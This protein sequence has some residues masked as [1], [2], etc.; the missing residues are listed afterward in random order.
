M[1]QRLLNNLRSY[2]NSRT[3]RG[4]GFACYQFNIQKF[5]IFPRIYTYPK[6]DGRTKRCELH[7]RKWF[8]KRQRRWWWRESS[9]KR[10][11]ESRTLW[12][13]N[14]TPSWA[15]E[16]IVFFATACTLLRDAW[17]GRSSGEEKVVEGIIIICNGRVYFIIIT[18]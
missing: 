1:A 15:I 5:R 9:K 7:W 2:K 11:N 13:M 4:R 8:L 14:N 10:L 3:R 17:D 6:T 18:G 16:E 12:R